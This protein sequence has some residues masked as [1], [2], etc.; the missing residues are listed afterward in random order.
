M[1]VLCI[2]SMTTHSADN[3]HVPPRLC[4]CMCHLA[5]GC[6]AATEWD[7]L[8][9]V[10]TPSTTSLVV[11]HGAFNKVFILTAL[12]IPVDSAGFR[13]NHFAFPNCGMIELEWPAGAVH[14]TAWRRRYPIESDWTTREDELR[15]ADT[16][17]GKME[18]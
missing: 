12:G 7:Q 6:R 15:R 4:M 3:L 1:A 8:R 9:A 17:R 13:D 11:A 2:T 10:T 14:A 18:L 16:V 5:C